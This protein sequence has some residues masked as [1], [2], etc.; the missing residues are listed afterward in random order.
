MPN[1]D[2]EQHAGSNRDAEVLTLTLEPAESQALMQEAPRRMEASAQ[3]VLLA[4]LLIGWRDWTGKDSLRLDVEGHGR[5]IL[6]D[7]FDVSRTVGWFTTVFPVHL[8]LPRDQDSADSPHEMAVKAVQ[9]A[10][11]ALPLRGAAHGLARHLTPD[12]SVR[13]ALAAQTRPAVLFNLLGT[14]D[15]TLPPESRL[16]VV[17]EPQGRARSPE[18]PRAYVLELNARVERGALI[19]SIEYS[20]RSYDAETIARF[21]SALRDALLSLATRSFKR[22]T[23]PGV[24]ASSLAIVADLLAELDDA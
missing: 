9:N 22:F 23:L 12:E 1:G 2:V 19:V 17:D 11:D 8:A 15:V 6:G 5:D 21:A 16:R 4:A 14:H 18:A 7:A 24:D 13:S 10:L 3:A 20:R